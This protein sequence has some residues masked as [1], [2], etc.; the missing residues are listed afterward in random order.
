MLMEEHEEQ[1]TEAGSAHENNSEEKNPVGESTAGE[2]R[3]EG[4]SEEAN[5]EKGASSGEPAGTGSEE[6]RRLGAALKN[7]GGSLDSLEQALSKVARSLEGLREARRTYARLGWAMFLILPVTYLLEIPVSVLLNYFLPGWQDT[8]LFW[9]VSFGPLYGAAF[10]LALWILRPLPARPPEERPLG[11]LRFAALIPVTLVLTYAGSA[12]SMLLLNLLNRSFGTSIE[13]P[14]EGVL[15]GDT[16]P[17]PRTLLMV[18]AAPLVEEFVFRKAVL[19]RTRVY[20]EKLALLASAL[21]FGLSHGNL[22]QFIYALLLGLV[23]GYVYLRTGR[24]RYTIALH[25]FVNF[26][27]AVAAPFVLAHTGGAEQGGASG[28]GG[29]VVIVFGLAV[30]LLCGGGIAILADNWRNLHFE[31]AELELPKGTRLRTAF[32]HPGMALLFISFVVTSVV[33]L[34]NT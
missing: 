30:L 20:G 12:A 11:P 28:T 7:L 2:I 26:M 4:T 31:A 18:C 3:R 21:L 16:A 23:F 13:N 22:S 8:W 9:A 14:L 27:G 24:L 32:A 5:P 29:A 34:L 33:T 6:D 25:M 10:P 17:L 1:I 19:D 15:T